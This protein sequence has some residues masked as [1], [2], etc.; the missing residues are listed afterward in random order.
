MCCN[1]QKCFFLPY[2]NRKKICSSILDFTCVPDKD[3][4][5]D[6]NF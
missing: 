2:Y 5:V 1:A 6:D 3:F 4:F